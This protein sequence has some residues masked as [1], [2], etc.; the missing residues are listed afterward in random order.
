MPKKTKSQHPLAILRT[1]IGETSSEFGAQFGVE[2]A[3][4]RG[5]E[6]GRATLT[7]QLA[8][9]ISAWYGVQPS[10]LMG[11]SGSPCAVW[12]RRPYTKEDYEFYLGALDRIVKKLKNETRE[13]FGLLG[14][15]WIGQS[16]DFG[17]RVLMG[18]INLN[19]AVIEQNLSPKTQFQLPSEFDRLCDLD[20][21]KIALVLT[22]VLDVKRHTVSES[23]EA[24]TLVRKAHDLLLV[25]QALP[26]RTLELTIVDILNEP[27]STFVI[28][29]VPSVRFEQVL[30]AKPLEPAADVVR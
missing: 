19:S 8:D 21:G 12:T 26:E 5:I 6:S 2:G 25:S 11:K 14:S 3:S 16:K 1:V 29:Y 13:V 23:H 20:L 28:N 15:S 27:D 18:Y 4:I 9:K 17:V 30:T 22:G 7:K 10:S 24:G